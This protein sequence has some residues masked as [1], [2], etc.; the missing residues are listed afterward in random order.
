MEKLTKYW[1]DRYVQGGNS[2]AGSYGT[3]AAVKANIINH[4]INEYDIRTVNEIG[5]G[6]GNNLLLY[7]VKTAYT[8]YD[9]SPKAIE[10]CNDKTKK[11]RNSLKFYFTTEESGMDL[12]ADLCLCLDVWYHQVD[13]ED[14]EKL[15]D[16]LFVKGNWKYIIIYSMDSNNQFTAEGVPFAAHLKNREVL[17]KVKE[18]PNWEVVYW[19]SG[20][21]TSDNKTKMFPAEKKFFLFKRKD[22]NDLEV[23]N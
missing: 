4:W 9:I 20:F 8:G 15:C 14:F 17:S 6:D 21:N 16:T 18:F 11:M 2:G 3:E 1:D 10:M 5:C 22:E 12:D 19:V 13:D 7:D 23:S